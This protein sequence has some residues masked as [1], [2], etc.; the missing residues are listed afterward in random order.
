MIK[1]KKVNIITHLSIILKHQ[2][3]VKVK[4]NELSEYDKQAVEKDPKERAENDLNAL[5]NLISFNREDKLTAKQNEFVNKIM[6]K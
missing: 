3:T 5:F 4:D 2:K 1:L 6:S